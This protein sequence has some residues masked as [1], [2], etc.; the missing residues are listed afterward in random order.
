LSPMMLRNIFFMGMVCL[1]IVGDGRVGLIIVT[2][3]L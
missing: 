1:Q 2:L 3:S